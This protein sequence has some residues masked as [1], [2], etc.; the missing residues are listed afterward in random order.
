MNTLRT[1]QELENDMI[2]NDIQHW[3]TK[4]QRAIEAGHPNDASAF[5][6]AA[7]RA[8]RKLD[9]YP[10]LMRQAE[11]VAEPMLRMIETEEPAILAARKQVASGQ[12]TVRMDYDLRT[13][14]LHHQIITQAT[15]E[16]RTVHSNIHIFRASALADLRRAFTQNAAETVRWNN[17]QYVEAAKKAGGVLVMKSA[18]A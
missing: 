16:G 8:A 2:K 4:C 7:L 14:D 18:A 3:A 5:A 11:Q 13:Y 12:A 15:A 9:E 10:A 6:Q 1:M 17:E